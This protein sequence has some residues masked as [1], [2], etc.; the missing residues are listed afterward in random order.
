MEHIKEKMKS[1]RVKLFLTICIATIVIIGF[2]IVTNNVVLETFYLYSKQNTLKKVYEQINSYYSTPSQNIDLEL[3]LGKIAINNNFDLLIC[4]DDNVSI[5]TTDSD[6][7]NTLHE[8][9]A[10][11]YYANIEEQK[12]V[13]YSNDKMNIRKVKERKSGITYILLSAMLDNGYM[14]YIR[15]PIAPIQESVKISN[16]FLLLIGGIT[17][18]AAGI[19]A[20]FIS[21][22]FT[23]PI[24]EL[25]GIARKMSKLDFSQKYRITDTEDE[26]NNLGKS[27]NIMSDKLEKTIKQLRSTNIE[28]EKDIEEKSRIDEMR[29]QFISDVSHELKTPIA[30]IQGYSEGLLENVTTDEESRKFYAE[31]ILDE[32]NKMDRL[33]KQLLELMKLEYGKREFQNKKFNIVELIKEVIRKSKVMLD[34]NNI[35]V[36]L[37]SEEQVYVNADEFYIEQV[38]TNYFTNAMK[39]V[40]DINGEKLIKISV[41]PNIEENKVRI[42]VFNTGENIA[43]EDLNRIWN[44]FYK[45]DT[46][47]NRDAG[48]SG[49]G[50]SLVKAI[51]N[52]YQNDYG[53]INTENG[54]EFYFDLDLEIE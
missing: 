40:I 49:I 2:L 13:L 41:K 3:E 21:K 25:D 15:I 35:K 24:L 29:K 42:S 5:Y 11:T 34:E 51:M 47:R 23:E 44:R 36:E 7:M 33:V 14:L 38:V 10:I 32:T 22:K 30:L 17:I 43:E 12:N 4:S 6:F 26:I 27:I 37:D 46:S 18:L 45:V 53:V 50:L 31:V 52:N 28:L 19:F 20:S 1:V 48:G 16:N 8:M 54:V 39:H 9:N